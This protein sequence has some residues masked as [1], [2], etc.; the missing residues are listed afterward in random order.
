VLMQVDPTLDEEHAAHRFAGALLIPRE[1]VFQ[2]V[3]ERRSEV[4]WEELLLLKRLWGVSVVSI[5]HRLR[6]LDVI[7][8]VHYEWWRREIR[9][10]GYAKTEP[11][12]LPREESTWAARRLARAEAEGLLSREQAAAYAESPAPRAPMQI[13]ARSLMRLSLED[14][15]VLLRAHAERL[16]DYYEDEARGDWI[17]GGLGDC[18]ET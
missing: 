7:T 17:D 15:R 11:M 3:G 13:D 12:R 16:S 2:E 5:L 6:E 8:E 14:R 9:A 4:A 18:E 10:L 1:L